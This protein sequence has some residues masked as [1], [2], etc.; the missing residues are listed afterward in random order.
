MKQYS[1]AKLES[2]VASLNRAAE[3]RQ[4]SEKLYVHLQSHSYLRFR[5]TTGTIRAAAK[6]IVMRHSQQ[7]RKD[8]LRAA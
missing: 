3:R 2:K 7:V 4:A 5:S 8:G 1:D 6:A